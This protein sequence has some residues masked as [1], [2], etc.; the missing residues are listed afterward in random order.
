MA[1]KLTKVT[2]IV[3]DGSLGG[4]PSGSTSGA[5]ETA[6]RIAGSPQANRIYGTNFSRVQG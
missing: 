4:E 2:Q 6:A 1:D 3:V 5:A